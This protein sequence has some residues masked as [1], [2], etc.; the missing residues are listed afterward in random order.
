MKSRFQLQVQCFVNI[1]KSQHFVASSLIISHYLFWMFCFHSVPLI[2]KKRGDD[3]KFIIFL[4][5][6][7]RFF[8]YLVEKLIK[9]T[10]KFILLQF[11]PLEISYFLQSR[12][13]NFSCTSNFVRFA[14]LCSNK[15]STFPAPMSSNRNK[16]I[17]D[18]L[19]AKREHDNAEGLW[20]IHDKLYDLINFIQRHPG[21]A[22]W[23]KLTQG[24]DITELFETHHISGKA[25]ILLPNF[26]V[27]EAKKPRNYRTT[28]CDDG[29]YRTL[30][31]KVADQLSVVNKKLTK[32]SDVNMILVSLTWAEWKTFSENCWRIC[33]HNSL[34]C[35]FDCEA[36]QRVLRNFCRNLSDVCG[37]HKSK[38]SPSTRQLANVLHESDGFELP[39]VARV[40]CNESPHVSQHFARLG[41]VKHGT[42]D[43]NMVAE[44]QKQFP[45]K[46]FSDSLPF[47]VASFCSLCNFPKVKSFC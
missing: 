10:Q 31:I 30:K 25:E 20:R 27:R 19:E 33:Y 43:A 17:K 15:L 35:N 16:S 18:W 3:P 28:F 44:R 45:Q 7:L 46:S 9:W 12:N 34:E 4:K 21:G 24:T 37:N 6:Y 39:R 40:T 5:M 23:L 42:D 41:N 2:T 1:F 36:Q 22:D 13:F 14:S 8:N 32:T 47:H 26:Y 29:F 38:L 11:R